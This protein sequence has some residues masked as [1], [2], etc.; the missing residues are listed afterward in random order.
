MNSAPSPSDCTP[1]SWLSEIA[2][3]ARQ[4]AFGL[5]VL[6]VLP[7]L[8]QAMAS[9]A[10]PLAGETGQKARPE[11]D[12][13]IEKS[14]KAVGIPGLAI[15]VV[16]D[17]KIIYAKGYG[18]RNVSK[19]ELVTPETVFGVG[20][21][22]KSFTATSLAML[23]DEGK[24]GWDVPVKEY[25]PS[26][27]TYDPYVTSLLSSRDLACH[28]TGIEQA[29]YLQWRPTERADNAFHPTRADIVSAFKYLRPS[30]GFRTTFA[31]KND[32]WVVAGAVIEATSGMTWDR[33][34]HERIFDRL[35]MKRSSTSVNETDALSNVS[36][37]HIWLRGQL[38]PINLVNADVPGPMGSI[39]S[40]VLDLAQYV[41]FHLGDGTFNNVR[42]LKITGLN[43]LHDPQVVDHGET[44][45]MGTGH[46][47]QVSYGLGWWVQ[48][49]RGRKL[50]HHAGEIVGGSANVAFLPGEH[51]G[52]VVLANGDSV[53]MVRALSLRAI[54]TFLGLASYDW[55][56][57]ALAVDRDA[58]AA[59]GAER[60]ERTRTRVIG[61]QPSHALSA[62]TGVYHNGAY[63]DLRISED[64]N[65]LTARLWTFTGDLSHWNYDTFSFEWDERHYYLHVIPER[66]NL[67]R[68]DTGESGVVN[69]VHFLSLGEFT[70]VVPAGASN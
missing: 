11:F 51:F 25:V 37:A 16:K 4:V 55:S 38:T 56:A 33:F 9:N 67:V 26:F 70:R 48:D 43:E 14:M 8:A 46:T 57:R 34:I 17:D 65:K 31:Y 7:G 47:Q 45:T 20:S 41:R 58:K 29:N 63:G 59:F 35:G 24:V 6:L 2:T 27:E 13:Y 12:R 68:F 21:V 52:V 1:R 23:V 60:T 22:T 39:N 50:V 49:Y 30:E 28:R 62:Y 19:Q 66:Q 18:T 69:R 5:L 53:S 36:S 40:T 3:G 54:D 15:A 10:D 32:T 42:L 44:L 61:T 64:G